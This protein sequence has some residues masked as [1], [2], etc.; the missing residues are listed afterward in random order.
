MSRQNRPNARDML[1]RPNAWFSPSPRLFLFANHR[2]ILPWSHLSLASFPFH[3]GPS[4]TLLVWVRAWSSTRFLGSPSIRTCSS[5]PCFTVIRQHSTIP[6]TY[7]RIADGQSSHSGP[8]L[9]SSHSHRLDGRRCQYR[10]PKIRPF[11]GFLQ[12]RHKLISISQEASDHLQIPLFA[13]PE[14]FAHRAL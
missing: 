1:D 4:P 12:N 13:V 8:G 10:N 11:L 2:L 9:T 6:V 3:T 5:L 14:R 7:S